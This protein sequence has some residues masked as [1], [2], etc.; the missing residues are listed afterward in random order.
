MRK[1]QDNE[2]NSIEHLLLN[3]YRIFNDRGEEIL[4]SEEDAASAKKPSSAANATL[5]GRGYWLRRLLNLN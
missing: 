3:G 5:A 1:F 2:F 4:L